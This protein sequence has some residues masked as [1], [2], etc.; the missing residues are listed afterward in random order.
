M[1]SEKK[2][3]LSREVESESD[4]LRDEKSKRRRVLERK[5]L[6]EKESE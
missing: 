2:R 1:E 3:D 6:K 5:S 4:S